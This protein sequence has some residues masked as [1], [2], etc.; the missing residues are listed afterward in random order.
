ML[1]S[2]LPKVLVLRI[3]SKFAQNSPF[4][5]S[6]E[7]FFTQFWSIFGPNLSF[8]AKSQAS[9]MLSALLAI[10]KSADQSITHLLVNRKVDHTHAGHLKVNCAYRP[11]SRLTKHMRADLK[12]DHTCWPHQCQ[13]RMQVDP[14]VVRLQGRLNTRRST[15]CLSQL[16]G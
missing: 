3:L 1:C 9:R 12:A 13:L 2:L 8:S 11:T 14:A 4:L 6:F 15:S 10:V 5:A 16:Q 7:H